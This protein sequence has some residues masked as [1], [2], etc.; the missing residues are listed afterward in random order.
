MSTNPPKNISGSGAPADDADVVGRDRQARPRRRLERP[1]RLDDDARSSRRSRAGQWEVAAQLID[2]WMEEAKV[3]YV[4]YQ[5]WDEGFVAF[6]RA[7]ACR[8]TRSQA[9]IERVARAA[10]LPGRQR[11]SRR[12]AR[13]E[14]LG[15]RRPGCSRTGCAR[16]EITAEE[17]L[18]ALDELR[19]GWRQLHDRGADFQAGHA[20]VRRADGSARPRSRRRTRSCSSRT[21]QERYGPFDIR[22]TPVRGDALPQPLPL[23]R[24]DARPP[25]RAGPQ[26]RHGGRRARRPLRDQLRSVR[27]GRPPDSAATRSRDTGSRAEAPYDFGVTQEEH[28][29]AWNEK[30]VCY[31]CAHCCFALEHW[32]A[33]AVGPPAARHRLAALPGRDERARAEE[34]HVDDLQDA[35]RHPAP[36]R[37]SG[38]ASSDPDS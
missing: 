7:R 8:R 17:A 5:V 34:V 10:R 28:D 36:R 13:W 14:A 31:Y 20:H 19:E 15:D 33:R 18:A 23:V 21:S 26:R 32:P 16:F 22:E 3:V 30:G 1:G 6:L 27:L 12:R 24:G 35:R 37:T 29:W 9:E 25:R 38:S 11:R 4:I 2:Y